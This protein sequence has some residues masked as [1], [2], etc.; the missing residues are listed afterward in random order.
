MDEHPLQGR[1]EIL[2]ESL[3]A[4]ENGISFGPMSHLACM[5]TTTMHRD[6][7]DNHEVI[8]MC[9]YLLIIPVKTLELFVRFLS[10]P[11]V[12][13]DNENMNTDSNLTQI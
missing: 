12:C 13:N 5:H 10:V 6:T 9:M 7:Q 4:T 2:L 11:L 8:C 3:H 1:I